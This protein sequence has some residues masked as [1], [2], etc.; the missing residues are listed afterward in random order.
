MNTPK[1]SIAIITYNQE[2]FIRETLDGAIKQSY[3]NLE[4]VV[5]DDGSSDGT[6]DIIL[7]YANQYPR[8]FKILLSEKN[9][10]ISENFNRAFHA[11]TG[12]YIAWLGGDDI[13]YPDKIALQVAA[14]EKDLSVDVCYHGVRVF[15]S[16]SGRTIAITNLRDQ[17]KRDLRRLLFDGV[18][19]PGSA[20]M[21]RR[22]SCPV[23]GFSY[24]IPVASD[25]LFFIETMLS[26][27]VLRVEV[28]LG[29]NRGLRCGVR[30][31]GSLLRASSQS[32]GRDSHHAVML[33]P[34]KSYPKKRD[35]GLK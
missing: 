20:V 6:V 26:G 33:R 31:G 28:S 23:N 22:S 27:Y 8:I 32:R 30:R 1:V 4:I 10:G 9:T 18:S 15:D 7:E 11:C 25:W 3:K 2:A 5:S 17:R 12:K 35:T 16:S 19:L 13:F 34:Q 14:M 24:D 29:R 21:V